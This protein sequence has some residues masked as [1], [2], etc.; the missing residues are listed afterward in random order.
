MQSQGTNALRGVLS[1]AI[2]APWNTDSEFFQMALKQDPKGRGAGW[3]RIAIAARA[4]SP[5]DAMEC[6]RRAFEANPEAWGSWY[7]AFLKDCRD[8]GHAA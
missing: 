6:A 7:S 5:W 4:T 1:A 3:A 8:A 2:M